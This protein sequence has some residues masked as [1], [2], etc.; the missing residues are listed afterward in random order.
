M[1]PNGN[2]A[3]LKPF[4]SGHKSPRASAAKLRTLTRA[5]LASPEMVAIAV[6]IAKDVEEPSMVR[7]KAVESVLR[8]AFPA[9]NLQVD[10][11]IGNHQSVEW[12]ELRFITPGQPMP[13]THRITFDPERDVEGNETSDVG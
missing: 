11:Q 8:V 6:A 10:E 2:I 12:L 5:R 1:N 13:E 3:N 9:K 7:L 4:K